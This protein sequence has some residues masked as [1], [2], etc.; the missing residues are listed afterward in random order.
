V[1]SATGCLLVALSHPDDEIGCVGTIAAHR[2]LGVRVVLVFL[3]RGE[4][5]EA[6]GP[7]SAE[8]VGAVRIQHAQEIARILDCEIRFLDFADTHIEYTSEASYRVARVIAEIK[9]DAVI[10]WGEAWIRG[11]RHPDHQATGQIVRAAVTMARMKRAVAPAERTAVAAI[12][13]LRDRHSQIPVAAID[14]TPYQNLIHEVGR[15]YRER[16]GWLPEEWLRDPLR[17]QGHAL[18]VQAA[19]EFD[20]YESVPGLRRSLLGDH[21]AP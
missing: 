11:R 21:L 12:F 18:G 2:A 3:T 20:A 6:L 17:R 8:E 14:V 13:A 7:L 9:P 15:F 19:E 4:M 5:T 1:N 16:V 10:T